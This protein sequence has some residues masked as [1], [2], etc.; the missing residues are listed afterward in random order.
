MR[1]LQREFGMAILYISHDLGVIA[2][3]ADDVA[4][5]YLGR[6]VER[7]SA[8]N[9]F[10]WPRHPYT[11][12][13]LR[14]VPRLGKRSKER[15]EAIRGTVPSPMAPRVGCSFFNR[16]SVAIPG[17]CDRHGPALVDVE[18]AHGAACFHYPAVLAAAGVDASVARA[19]G[20][21]T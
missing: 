1:E 15:L 21:A 7:A 6:I 14:A 20:I 8:A 16:C 18:P 13:L 17:L 10:R 4:V 5:M 12:A 19:E 3:M 9:L 2:Q 11:Q